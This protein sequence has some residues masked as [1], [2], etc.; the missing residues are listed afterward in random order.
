MTTEI[1]NKI[2][3]KNNIL[4][5]TPVF[6]PPS[7]YDLRDFENFINSTQNQIKSIIPKNILDHFNSAKTKDEIRNAFIKM[8]VTLPYILHSNINEKKL[9]YSISFSFFSFSDLA[10]IGRASC[11]ERV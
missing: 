7:N 5:I 4:E 10:E 11:R 6:S 2:D 8:N 1:K 3:K 9:P